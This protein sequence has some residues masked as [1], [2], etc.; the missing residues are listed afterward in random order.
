MRILSL[1]VRPKCEKERE[2]VKAR[3]EGG[4]VVLRSGRMCGN[5]CRLRRHRKGNA[6]RRQFPE[7]SHQ[8][9]ELIPMIPFVKNYHIHNRNE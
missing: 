4:L 2:E 9:N 5:E 3:K 7:R 6:M 8:N 1:L